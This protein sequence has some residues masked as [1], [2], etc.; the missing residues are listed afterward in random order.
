M[1]RFPR[2][3]DSADPFSYLR[4]IVGALLLVATLVAVA[5]AVSGVAPRAI[6]LVTMF[7]GLYGLISGFT[8]GVLEPAIDF[9]GRMMYEGGGGAPLSGIEALVAQGE[10]GLAAER[11]AEVSQTEGSL[12]A[13]VRRTT[14][15]A[16][17]LRQ[18][19]EAAAELESLRDHRPLGPDDDIRVGLLLADLHEHQLGDPGRAMVELR[20][21]LDRYPTARGVRRIRRMLT[22]LREARFGKADGPSEPGGR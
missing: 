11:Y 18:P 8:D 16:G 10:Y 9:L 14:L 17:P 2:L 6:L 13:A 5:L 1:L 12:E 20:R 4:V 3:T 19:E 22:T 21:L 7:W 15:L